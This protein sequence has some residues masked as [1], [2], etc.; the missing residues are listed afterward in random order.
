MFDRPAAP[1]RRSPRLVVTADRVQTRVNEALSNRARRRGWTTAALGY[2]GYA[3]Q[4]RAR[5]HGRLVLAPAGTDPSARVSVPGWRRLLTLE[6]PN[7][8]IDVSVGNSR[9]RA[10]ADAAGLI[11]LTIPLELPPGR[12]PGLLHVECARLCWYPCTSPSPMRPEESI[13]TSTKWCGSPVF[14]SKLRGGPSR[15][16]ARPA[17]R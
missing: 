10:R 3:A 4:G 8:E 15:A 1:P 5:V 9:V 14:P 16:T 7:G 11:D 17:V 2:P 6:Q 13:A 12:I